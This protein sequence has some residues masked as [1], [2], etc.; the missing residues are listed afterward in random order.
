M[1]YMN[2]CGRILTVQK[3]RQNRAHELMR[4]NFGS[5]KDTSKTF[6]R[7]YFEE[8]CLWKRTVKILPMNSCGRILSVKKTH[9]NRPHEFKWTNFVSEKDTSKSSPWIHVDEFCLWKRH[10]K[11]VPMNS[12]GRILSVTKGTFKS[13]TWIHLDEF[14]LWKR[15]V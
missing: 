2:S 11:I 5:E 10:V 3:S 8:F 14:C 15:H 12:C 7:I 1:V 4:T 13:S 9:Q 6:L